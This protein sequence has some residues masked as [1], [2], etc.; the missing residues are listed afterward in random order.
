MLPLSASHGAAAG[1]FSLRAVLKDFKGVT[2]FKLGGTHA[3]A[4]KH[5]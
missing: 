4:G 3:G 5:A 2:A 1:F